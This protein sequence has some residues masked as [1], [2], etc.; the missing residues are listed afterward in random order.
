MT[1][2]ERPEEPTVDFETLFQSED[3]LQLLETADTQGSIKTTELG[4]LLDLHGFDA[5]ESDL[6]FRELE[7]RGYELI[8]EERETPLQ[9]SRRPSRRPPTRCSSSCARRGDIRC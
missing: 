3:F 9:F 5:V 6:V 4:E 2:T 7:A 1:T 8:E